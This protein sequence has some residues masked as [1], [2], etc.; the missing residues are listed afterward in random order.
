MALTK[1]DLERMECQIPGCK[2]ESHEFVLHS[3]CHYRTPTWTSY[4]N[5][6]LT[7]T[8]S[9]CHKVVAEIAVMA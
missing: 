5:G 8:C 7:I 9:L 1:D 6:V 2:H 3:R 4:Q